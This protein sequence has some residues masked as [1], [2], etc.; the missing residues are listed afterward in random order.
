MTGWDGCCCSSSLSTVLVP[1]A[2]AARER[3]EP[4]ELVMS[5]SSTSSRPF[6]VEEEDEGRGARE[7]V[8]VVGEVPKV[9]AERE[10][11]GL[12]LSSRS[13]VRGWRRARREEMEEGLGE[14]EA[15][16]WT[17]RQKENCQK[18]SSGESR[19]SRKTYPFASQPRHQ[20]LTAREQI[21]QSTTSSSGGGILRPLLTHRRLLR[22]LIGRSDQSWRL[23]PADVR[24][25][26][27]GEAVLLPRPTDSTR[28]CEGLLFEALHV[29]VD[30]G[31]A[32]LQL[33]SGEGGL[34]GLA[35][36]HGR[37]QSRWSASGEGWE[38]KGE[39]DV[40]QRQRP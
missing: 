33:L 19:E 1:F 30:E 20:L 34:F 22:L 6:E 29:F 15:A 12:A 32:F 37:R 31:I 8:G 36:L 24:V 27:G 40:Q 3:E 11:E 18:G 38:K 2:M 13:P 10:G 17:G 35:S 4:K 14:D 23:P 39:E 7:V 25:R 21:S 9:P 26:N 16:N 28:R 5:G